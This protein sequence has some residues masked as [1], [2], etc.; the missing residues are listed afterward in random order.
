[1]GKGMNTGMMDIALEVKNIEQEIINWRRNLHRTPEVGLALPRTVEYITGEL[2]KLGVQ[3]HTL[4]NGNGIAGVIKGSGE[5]KTIALRADIDGLPVKEETGLEFASVNNNMHA[6]GHDAHAA[7][8]LGAIKILNESKD[9]FAGNVKFIFQ[10]G[11]EYPGGA[12]PMIEEGVLKNPEVD[13][14]IGLHAGN[15]IKDLPK[16]KIGVCYG[17]LMSAADRIWIK[18]KGKGSHGAY[19]HLSI[20]PI[21]TASEVVTALQTIISREIHP[22]EPAVLSICRISGG[23]NQNII[24][25]SVELEGTV[26]TINAS[27]K[28]KIAQRIEEIVKGITMAHNAKYEYFYD[29]KY[30]PVINDLDFTAKFVQWAKKIIKEEAIVEIKQPCMVGEDMSY[31][32][33]Q[34]PG[35]FFFLSNPKEVD[36]EI[37]PHHNPKFDVD[38]SL[39]WMGTALFVQS[40]IDFLSNHK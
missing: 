33:Q 1:M 37:Y 19:P 18:I 36:G 7:M 17:N 34:V 10:P 9:K 5:G 12:K 14:I 13:A 2:K 22:S 4:V 20:D 15:I 31:F 32:L 39:L 26:R 16:G 35:T 11:E 24:P 27:T 3:Y 8:L 6:C 23:Y 30:P 29:Y 28:E 40:C 38:E 21:A 25:D